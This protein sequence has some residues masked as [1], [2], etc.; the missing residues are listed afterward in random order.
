MN[1][2]NFRVNAPPRIPDP[3]EPQIERAMTFHQQGKLSDAEEIYKKILETNPIDFDALNM[4][5]LLACQTGRIENGL[6]Y[7]SKA[8]AINPH[9]AALQSNLGNAQLV[10]R[11][12]GDALDSCDRAVAEDPT[13][14][15][16]WNNRGIALQELGRL[17][18]ALAS[19]DRAIALKPN[20]AMA[21]NI[22]G[23]ILKELLRYDEALSNYDKAIS[24]NPNF[25]PAHCNRGNLLLLL[26]RLEAAVSSFDRALRLKADFAEAHYGRASALL[27]LGQIEEAMGSYKKAIAAKPD[28]VDAYINL[29]N[30]F[31]KLD[32]L[33]DA[34]TI[35]SQALAIDPTQIQV[36]IN[37]IHILR[38]LG[39]IEDAV[40]AYNR[41]LAIDPG[42]MEVHRSL[43]LTL[44]YHP[45]LDLETY[46]AEH[47]RFEDRFARPH[48][49]EYRPHPNVKDSERRLRIGYL[50][51]DFH[52]HTVA[53]SLL[54]ILSDHS[55]NNF[56]IYIYAEVE[57]PD[58]VTEAFRMLA[59]GW[60]STVG[61][62]DREVADRI[63]ADA[64]DIL[65]CLAGRFDKNRP[66]VCAYKPAPIQIGFHDVA[67]SGLSAIDYLISDRV[68]TPRDGAERFAERLL[69][70]PDFYLAAIPPDVPPILKRAGL[71]VVFGCLNNPAKISN[72]VLD[73]WGQ[74]LS[75]VPDSRLLLRYYGVYGARSLR[76]RIYA[77]L[78]R[79]GVS[80]DRIDLP[81]AQATHSQS[82]AQYNDIDIAL[83]TFPFSGSTT[84]FDALIMGVPVVTVPG[85]TM[86]SRWTASMLT[87]LGITDLI[88]RSS[89][90]YVD[91]A[92]SLAAN[93]G[94]RDQ[95]RNSLRERV[96]QS[97]LCDHASRTRH[98]ERFYRAVWRRWCASSPTV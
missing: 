72:E 55:R 29:G 37:S 5:G 36:Q 69:C 60:Q 17:D 41:V 92:C 52:K 82:L 39:L 97:P 95:L 65:V 74:I 23:V 50:S 26:N 77:A 96:S 57:R 87:S 80:S 32:L 8:A 88:A 34:Q 86:V 14:A 64:V 9:D 75:K 83:D 48:Y 18:D 58:D 98:I 91:I 59:D 11:R 4:M 21:F 85:E 44:A 15:E 63:R 25:A 13:L 19:Y 94:R 81:G 46:F 68:L 70:L 30:I 22:R 73:L 66:L 49:A 62:S 6:Q 20:Y 33:D 47:R 51:S 28:F 76:E 53:R 2:S 24:V 10:L 38:R 31:L 7:L 35:Y 3:I 1:T 42:N 61:L 56:E 84:T 79:H 40:I 12:F 89:K 54:P 90:D 27:Q 16:A 71:P 43:L 45:S 78:E 67:T 93:V